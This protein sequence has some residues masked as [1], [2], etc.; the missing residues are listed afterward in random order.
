M[1][2]ACRQA[3]PSPYRWRDRE[4][5]HSSRRD[6][7]G[8]YTKEA[9]DI[10]Q[11]DEHFDRNRKTHARVHGQNESRRMGPAGWHA[12]SPS[13]FALAIRRTRLRRRLPAWLFTCEYTLHS[14]SGRICL[15]LFRI[16]HSTRQ[17]DGTTS[18]PSA[19]PQRSSGFERIALHVAAIRNQ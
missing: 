1:R 15:T 17:C 11:Y 9:R 7:V 3:R 19:L 2:I 6:R 18:T 5:L 10:Q 8:T 12:M 14:L 4:F 13:H 16:D